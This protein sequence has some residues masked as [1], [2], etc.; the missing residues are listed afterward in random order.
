[1]YRVISG[2][3]VTRRPSKRAISIAS[4]SDA[5]ASGTLS[6][7]SVIGLARSAQGISHLTRSNRA[8]SYGEPE[9]VFF[10]R[11]HKI[12]AQSTQDIS[13]VD[14]VTFC[15][16][17]VGASS[18]RYKAQEKVTF[19]DQDDIECHLDRYFAP[20]IT[21]CAVLA[22]LEPSRVQNISGDSGQNKSGDYKFHPSDSGLT[23]TPIKDIIG[24]K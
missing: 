15:G 6:A 14:K 21:R 5:L 24:V 2:G 20:P 13:C 7:C 16:A 23:L 18:P 10:V 8:K 19:T 1:M 9:G 4:N 12:R 22:T 17:I 3:S 11:K